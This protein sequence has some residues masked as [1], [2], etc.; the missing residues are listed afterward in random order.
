[1]RADCLYDS[2]GHGTFV[3]SVL[4]DRASTAS[5]LAL[6]AFDGD[7]AS[8]PQWIVSAIEYSCIS[9]AHVILLSSGA[10]ED[11]GG[12]VS[13]AIRNALL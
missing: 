4:S 9:G 11:Q 7:G 3:S 8:K 2:H 6:K 1:M 5:I 12:P 13:E 10:I